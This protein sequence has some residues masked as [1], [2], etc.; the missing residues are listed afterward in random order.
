MN[1]L[2]VFHLS[3]DN[4]R[5]ITLL[6]LLQAD[7]VN[8]LVLCGLKCYDIMH[9]FIEGSPG[10]KPKLVLFITSLSALIQQLIDSSY[11]TNP[12]FS[13]SMNFLYTQCNA[14]HQIYSRSQQKMK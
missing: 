4:T 11:I 2:E 12:L 9:F 3:L 14:L 10:R 1:G 7:V 8:C 13:V 6:L 5:I